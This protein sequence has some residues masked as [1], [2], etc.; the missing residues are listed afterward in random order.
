[1]MYIVHEILNNDDMAGQSGHNAV[2]YLYA[3]LV[4]ICTK[5]ITHYSVQ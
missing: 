4:L 1:M 3:N 2:L 5:Q